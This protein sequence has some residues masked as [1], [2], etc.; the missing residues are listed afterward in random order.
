[1]ELARYLGDRA[2]AAALLGWAAENGRVVWPPARHWRR[3]GYSGAWLARLYVRDERRRT[4]LVVVKVLPAGQPAEVAAHR[5]A[6]EEAG[7]FRDHLAAPLFDPF[8]LPGGG[9]VTFQAPVGADT[10]MMVAADLP[11]T[12]LPSVLSELVRAL[13]GDWNRDPAVVPMDAVEALRMDL[14]AHPSAL[15]AKAP[16]GPADH[17]WVAING[18]VVPNPDQLTG[19]DSPLAG[20]RVDLTIGRVH[21]D[22]HDRNLLVQRRAGLVDPRSFALVDLMS[23]ASE[24]QLG[25]DPVRLLLCGAARLLN[26][27]TEPNWSLLTTVLTIPDEP[28]P[29]LL[30]P[31]ATDLRDAVYQTAAGQLRGCGTWPDQY[32]L[33]LISQGMAMATFEN[34]GVGRRWW[35][36]ELAG[37]AA[38]ELLVRLGRESTIPT[39]ATGPENPFEHAATVLDLT[40]RLSIVGQQRRRRVVSRD[41]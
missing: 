29:R 12:D 4:H 22:L 33:T 35:F 31:L 21:G 11:I 6:I 38:R 27:L 25:Q 14:A 10:D 34:L 13:L 8:R 26:H 2:V 32:L 20:A 36:F 3:A 19:P 40:R 16:I 30:P 1:M 18:I 15:Q 37:R 7:T 39:G 23:Y 9:L 28:L 41:A 17:P 5:L 24:R